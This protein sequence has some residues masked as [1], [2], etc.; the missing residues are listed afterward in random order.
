MESVAPRELMRAKCVRVFIPQ[1]GSIVDVKLVLL[2][3][4]N[5]M[6]T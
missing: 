5:R 1:N 3:R 4:P 6:M 2:I